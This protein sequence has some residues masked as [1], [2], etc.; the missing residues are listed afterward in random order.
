MPLFPSLE[1]FEA[2][3][4]IVNNDPAFRDSGTIDLVMGVDVGG[5][6]F[7]IVFDAWEVAEV[8][9]L[10][11]PDSDDL[12]FVLRMPAD[13]WRDLI[14]NIQQ[15]GKADLHHTLNTLDLENEDN[16]AQGPDYHRR[17][18][19]YRFNQSLQD[20]FDASARIETTFA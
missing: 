2:L 17:D 14:Q 3:R 7:K 15:H 8:A 13:N 19:F 12:D 11:D 4:D 6:A 18:K 1:W 5:Q 10:D 16:L 20:F 9:T